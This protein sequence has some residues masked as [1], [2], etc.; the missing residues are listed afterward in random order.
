VYILADNAAISPSD[1]AFNYGDG[2]FT[3]MHVVGGQVRLLDY[4]LRRLTHDA[5][6]LGIALNPVELATAISDFAKDSASEQYVMKVHVCAGE[7]GRGYARDPKKPSLVRFSVHDYP[8]HYANIKQRGAKLICAN[9]RLA[10]QPT[11]AGIKHMNRLEQVL[12]KQEVVNRDVDDALVFDTNNN[13]IEASAGNVFFNNG[14][15]WCTPALD[16]CG[17]NGVVRQCLLDAANRAEQPIKQGNYGIEDIATAQALVITNALMGV[18]PVTQLLISDAD[19]LLF[20]T[21]N[22]QWLDSLLLMK[23]QEE[24]ANFT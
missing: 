20:N 17:V 6:A 19:T 5:K 3:T 10:I 21:A 9:T 22:G 16:G 8:L 11:L 18:M 23:Y 4:H 12:I 24:N 13:V 2:V 7:G 15:Q 14:V 1:R